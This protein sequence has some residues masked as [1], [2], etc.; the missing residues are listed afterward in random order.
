M[1]PRPSPPQLATPPVTASTA[2][3]TKQRTPH[4]IALVRLA[5]N[6]DTPA[7]A[8]KHTTEGK[9]K[10]DILRYLKRT[11]AREVFHLTTLPQPVQSTTDL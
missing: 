6:P 4:R 1:A 3:A 9:N 11:I 10:K 7:H 8:A 2:V 5:T